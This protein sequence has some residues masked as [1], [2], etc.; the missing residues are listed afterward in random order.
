MTV[1]ALA[2]SLLVPAAYAVGS[3]TA[4]YAGSDINPPPPAIESM[5]DARN[6]SPHT[7]NNICGV[8]SIMPLHLFC[9]A[10]PSAGNF[11]LDILT[12][13]SRAAH[14]MP[15]ARPRFHGIAPG[16]GRD[17]AL[18]RRLYCV[19][20]PAVRRIARSIKPAVHAP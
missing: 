12:A 9:P 8:T 11:A 10:A 19:G 6:T 2:V 18:H 3:P 20:T 14:N 1:P 5:N 13:H 15:A 4:R 7:T 17:F 16:M